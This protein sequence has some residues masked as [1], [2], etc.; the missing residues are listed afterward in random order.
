MPAHGKKKVLE[1]VPIFIISFTMLKSHKNS[2]DFTLFDM[3]LKERVEAFLRGL[4][5]AFDI[6]KEC[7]IFLIYKC[8][9]FHHDF[10][11]I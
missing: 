9:E 10:V 2:R 3:L 1:I 8:I 5:K 6:S 7:K 4:S 11:G